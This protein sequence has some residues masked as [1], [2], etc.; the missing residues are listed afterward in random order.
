[1]SRVT[2]YPKTPETCL[3][4]VCD[5]RILFRSQNLSEVK[6]FCQRQWTR[7]Q[8]GKVSIQDFII[9]KEVRLGTYK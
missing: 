8:L 7:L 1:M 2:H 5:S 3:T 4:S 6:D 9:A